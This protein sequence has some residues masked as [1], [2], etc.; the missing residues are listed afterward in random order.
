[1][2][3]NTRHAQA[4]NSDRKI[5]EAEER[6]L[7]SQDACEQRIENWN[8]DVCLSIGLNACDSHE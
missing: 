2:L 8:I 6:R 3:L 4:G 1:M 7:G 5:H